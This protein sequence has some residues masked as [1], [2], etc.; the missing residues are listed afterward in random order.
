MALPKV[1][2]DEELASMLDEAVRMGSHSAT[3]ANRY[4]GMNRNLI[5]AIEQ[6]L[7]LLKTGRPDEARKQLDKALVAA[8]RALT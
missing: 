1:E 7:R 3:L 5:D 8:L 2:Q 6:A 4:L